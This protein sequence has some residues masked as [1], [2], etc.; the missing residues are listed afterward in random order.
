MLTKAFHERRR[1]LWHPY[2]GQPIVGFWVKTSG[3]WF[4]CLL[5][6]CGEAPV[7]AVLLSFPACVVPCSGCSTHFPAQIHLNNTSLLKSKPPH[8]KSKNRNVTKLIRMN[9]YLQQIERETSH[10]LCL[11]TVYSSLQRNYGTSQPFH[12]QKKPQKDKKIQIWNSNH[13]TSSA[14][15]HWAR[16]LW[17]LGPLE[18]ALQMRSRQ[19]FKLKSLCR[20]LS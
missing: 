12:H 7:V 1:M 18:N 14:Y 10:I 19:E 4:G 15:I 3:S 17:I 5:R 9:S 16:S 13:R 2:L 8:L 11:N 20:H 6:A